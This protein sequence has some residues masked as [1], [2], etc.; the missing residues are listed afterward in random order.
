M[1]EN[2]K[3]EAKYDGYA[4]CP[5]VVD[6]RHTILAEFNPQ[7]PLET[8]PFD[9]A[10]PTRSL[11]LGGT[12]NYSLKFRIKIFKLLMQITYLFFYLFEIK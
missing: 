6:R 10:K 11:E 9:Q 5:L 3:P 7:G 4:S 2:K 1:M 8:F 12:F